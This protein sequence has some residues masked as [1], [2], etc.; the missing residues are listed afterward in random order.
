MG[1]NPCEGINSADEI[2]NNVSK[3]LDV[4]ERH[5]LKEP[6]NSTERR[7]ADFLSFLDAKG[8]FSYSYWITFKA[9][10]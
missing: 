7:G 2:S 9:D 5:S 4:R 6:I 1:S 8:C 10:F 3:G